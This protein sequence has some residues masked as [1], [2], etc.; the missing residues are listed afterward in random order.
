MCNPNH[1][2]L[3]IIIIIGVIKGYPVSQF[4]TRFFCNI[5]IKN[6]CCNESRHLEHYYDIKSPPKLTFGNS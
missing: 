3:T 5:F 4:P 1:S 2:T 6:T